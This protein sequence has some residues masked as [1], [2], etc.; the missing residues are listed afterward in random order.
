MQSNSVL[1][2]SLHLW[3]LVHM[4]HSWGSTAEFTLDPT[5]D[6]G[7]LQHLF[8]VGYRTQPAYVNEL[9]EQA[10]AARGETLLPYFIRGT[11]VLLPTYSLQCKVVSVLVNG[12]SQ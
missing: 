1:R 8:L 5:S 6:L 4:S 7:F 12:L 3:I 2:I 11:I 10:Q 9:G